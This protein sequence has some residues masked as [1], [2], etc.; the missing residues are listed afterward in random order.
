MGIVLEDTIL[1]ALTRA[2]SA[3][4]D[5]EQA[6]RQALRAVQERHPDLADSAAKVA[7]DAVRRQ[8]DKSAAD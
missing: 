8:L 2:R 4:L 7:V 6:R 1:K 3:G 5:E